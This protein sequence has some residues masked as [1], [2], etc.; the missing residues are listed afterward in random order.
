MITFD[1]ECEKLHR[2]EGW[3]KNREDFEA[4][5]ST[6]MI[7]C[8]VC[9]SPKVK[10]LP[11][12]AAVHT[13]KGSSTPPQLPAQPREILSYY[14]ALGD[15]IDKNFEHVGEAF[16]DEARKMKKGEAPARS[17][18][19]VTTPAQEEEL[20]EEGIEFFKVALPKYDA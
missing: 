18:K 12:R 5:L 11:S 4:Q 8:P 20:A 13:S 10:K 14:R 16:A 9:N 15:F 2:F 7:S 17:I 6:G 1:L 3:F 19:G